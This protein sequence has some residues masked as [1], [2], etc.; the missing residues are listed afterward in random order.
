MK[1]NYLTATLNELIAAKILSFA[2]LTLL[3][4]HPVINPETEE[5][6]KN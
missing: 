2:K 3:G 1:R 4:K 5:A 6:T